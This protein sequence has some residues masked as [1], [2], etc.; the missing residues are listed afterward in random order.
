MKS[1][2]QVLSNVT[3]VLNRPKRKYEFFYKNIEANLK[4]IHQNFEVEEEKKL[5]ETKLNINDNECN[6]S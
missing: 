6:Y 1:T 4:E 2:M 3:D 5:D